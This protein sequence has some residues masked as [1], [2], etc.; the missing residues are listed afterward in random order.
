MRG[1]LGELDVLLNR[2]RDVIARVS[3]G[4]EGI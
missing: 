4:S 1:A 2:T 3:S